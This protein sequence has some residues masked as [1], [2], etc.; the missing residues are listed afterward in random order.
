MIRFSE[1]A[2][3]KCANV[4]TSRHLM[5]TTAYGNQITDCWTMTRRVGM[6]GGES[7]EDGDDDLG[8]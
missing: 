3:K 5:S 1:C 7:D 8:G 2:L 6:T 4:S